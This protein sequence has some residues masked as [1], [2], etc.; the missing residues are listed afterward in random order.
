MVIYDDIVVNLSTKSTVSRKIKNCKI[1]F[2][3]VKHTLRIFCDK[4]M[5]TFGQFYKNFAKKS[6]ISQKN[7]NRK[8]VFS[9][10]SEYCSSFETI[11]FAIFG[12]LF[13]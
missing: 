3:W 8:I 7:K 9:W 13:W 5:A 10:V 4:K 11:F 12:H 1:I 2:S 6:T